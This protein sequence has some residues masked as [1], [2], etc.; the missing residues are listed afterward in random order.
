MFLG[1]V[2]YCSV[3]ALALALIGSCGFDS[4]EGGSAMATET[5]PET[6]DGTSSSGSPETDG[7]SSCAGRGE[8]PTPE[9]PCC[10]GLHPQQL[11]AGVT[12]CQPPVPAPR[13]RLR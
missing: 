5:T 12:W 6:D 13:K 11:S 2:F 8:V 1:V 3:A 10:E 9:R 7:G 4:T